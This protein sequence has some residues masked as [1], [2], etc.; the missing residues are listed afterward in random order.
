MIYAK[1][2]PKN[3]PHPA[4]KREKKMILINSLAN[5]I[6]KQ[7]ISYKA[8]SQKKKENQKL[9]VW[10]M[11]QRSTEILSRPCP[12]RVLQMT[13][14]LLARG[15]LLSLDLI[16]GA[17]DT[18][19]SEGKR[20]RFDLGTCASSCPAFA[21]PSPS[22]SI[23]IIC[24]GCGHL[25]DSKSNWNNARPHTLLT[26]TQT[27]THAF[28]KMCPRDFILLLLLFFCIFRFYWKIFMTRATGSSHRYLSISGSVALTVSFFFSFILNCFIINNSNNSN[29]NQSVYTHWQKFM[30]LK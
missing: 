24:T 6:D 10:K 13:H 11:S 30:W 28:T 3:S 4:K 5:W 20:H 7:K 27:L 17:A 9:Q 21:V 8:G 16:W 18:P 25:F 29:K 1:K 14:K 22:P 12:G 15:D 19:P 26:H 2:D 23:V